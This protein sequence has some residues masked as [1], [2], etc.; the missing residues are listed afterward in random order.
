MVNCVVN[1]VSCATHVLIA[2]RRR[3]CSMSFTR[4]EPEKQRVTLYH[5][6]ESSKHAKRRNTM[7]RHGLT[8][9]YVDVGVGAGEFVCARAS[10]SRCCSTGFW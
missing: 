2:R 9:R 1:N 7:N 6:T 3:T 4:T 5:R 8:C 10:L